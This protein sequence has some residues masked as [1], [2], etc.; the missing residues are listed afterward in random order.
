MTD[1]VTVVSGLP[2]SGTSLMMQILEAVGIPILSEGIRTADNDNPEGYYEFERV[3]QL[4]KGDHAWLADVNGK[5]VKIISALIP[6][7]PPQ[8]HY[9][10][11]FME[12][13]LKEVLASQHKML[14]QRGEATDKVSDTELE[15]MFTRHLKQVQ[16]WISRQ[17]NISVLYVNYRQLVSDPK[18]WIEQIVTFLQLETDG[19]AM[20]GAVKPT[21]YRN[22]G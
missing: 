19:Q 20:I 12:R 8:H 11:L 2:R 1:A 16:D 14:I 15:V 22:R 5:A 6:Y 4:N 18:P 21:L 7:L 9:R 17:P 13:S 10:I 3:K